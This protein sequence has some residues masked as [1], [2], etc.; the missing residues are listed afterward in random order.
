MEL[1]KELYQGLFYLHNTKKLA[2]ASSVSN[3]TANDVDSANIEILIDMGFAR[4]QAIHALSIYPS[5]DEAAEHLLMS[6][7]PTQVII[8]NEAEQRT[9]PEVGY[10]KLIDYSI[11]YSL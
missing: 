8:H 6:G 11:P 3:V 5:V 9:P 2:N 10:L 7:A 4:E 1:F